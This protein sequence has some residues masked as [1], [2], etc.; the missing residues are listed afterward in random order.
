MYHISF[1][2]PNSYGNY[3]NDIV[4]NSNLS[5]LKSIFYYTDILD[6]SGN[7]LLVE[8]NR[9]YE[10]NELKILCKE[11]QYLLFLKLAFFDFI[12]GLEGEINS[13]DEFLQSVCSTMIFI[14]D[15]KIVNI[16]TKDKDTEKQIYKIISKYNFISNDA[17]TQNN[18]NVFDFF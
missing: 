14:T 6:S 16:I 13:I 1:L 5:N 10:P 2:I 17:Y 15:S 18:F 7:S 11:K 4:D 3:L 9:V 12:T 8:N